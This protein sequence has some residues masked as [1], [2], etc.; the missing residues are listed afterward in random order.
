[1]NVQLFRSRHVVLGA[2]LSAGVLAYAWIDY[3]GDVLTGLPSRTFRLG[4]GW[5]S[6]VTMLGVAAYALRKY[7]HR[8][9]YSPEFRMRTEFSAIEAATIGLKQL[10][11]KN[12]GAGGG[13]VRRV[14]KEAKGVVR[15][16][17]AHRVLKAEAQFDDA[18]TLRLRA[19][20]T[21]P[22]GRARYWMGAHIGY[23]LLFAVAVL[24]HGGLVSGSGIGVSMLLASAA[25]VISGVVGAVFWSMGPAWLTAAEHDLTIEEAHALSESLQRKRIETADAI[26]GAVKKASGPEAV[27]AAARAAVPRAGE[28][29]QALLDLAVLCDQ[30][31]KVHAEHARLRRIRRLMMGWKLVHVPAVI[32]LFALVALHVSIILSY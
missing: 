6:L 28:S 17:K 4:S 2:A 5:I 8:G 3:G 14:L 9:G 16:A 20:P 26:G 27:A 29:G 11:A 12:S 22:L 1:M 19:V 31:I 18:G 15:A 25:V 24:A 13:D 32:V 23:G 21:E 7:A 10:E 30:E